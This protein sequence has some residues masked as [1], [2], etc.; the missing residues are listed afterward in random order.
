MMVNNSH[1]SFSSCIEREEP[2]RPVDRSKNQQDFLKRPTKLGSNL[3]EFPNLFDKFIHVNEHLSISTN[4]L[5][6]SKCAIY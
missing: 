5:L 4:S 2:L 1:L 6:S 3:F